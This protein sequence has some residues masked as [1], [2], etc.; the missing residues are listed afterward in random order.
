MEI[1]A[2]LTP[3]QNIYMPGELFE[4]LVTW[5]SKSL[6][7]AEVTKNEKLTDIHTEKKRQIDVTIRIKNGPTEILGIVEARDRSRPVGVSYIEEV[8]SKK[9]SVGADFC[10]IVSNKG[11]Y[12][13]AID[14]AN[15]LGIRL[16]SLKD[17]LT[18]D[19]S[20]STKNTTIIEE[21]FNTENSEI[22][23]LNKSDDKIIV[24]HHSVL[25]Q[26]DSN[27]K[28]L[29]LKTKTGEALAH[30]PSLS[31]AFQNFLQPRMKIGRANGG[32]FMIF[33]DVKTNPELY[34]LTDTGQD[35]L[36]DYIKI[37]GFCWLEQTDMARTVSHYEDP[38]K[39]KV[40]AEIISV[41]ITKSKEKIDMIIEN[42]N[43]I[44]SVRKFKFRS[45]RDK[46]I[47]TP[48]QSALEFWFTPRKWYFKKDGKY[49]NIPLTGDNSKNEEIQSPPS[50]AS[51]EQ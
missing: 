19:W 25:A 51:S 42:P 45:N 43:D 6:Y 29:I 14:K 31:R 50:T 49:Y 27:Q 26:L 32:D 24:P 5:I 22:F 28:S 38:I 46:E 13:T 15:K 21:T 1:S 16:F 20:L 41:E 35:A 34:I 10:V 40:T 7:T 2:S 30:L 18:L 48:A 3:I 44:H 9:I 12:K 36:V 39:D 37:K 11:F 47:V 23:F 4:E 17:A 33:F 8:H